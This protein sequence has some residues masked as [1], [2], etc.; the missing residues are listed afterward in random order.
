MSGEWIDHP[1]SHTFTIPYISYVCYL[2]KQDILWLDIP[3]DDI[4]VVHELYR[5]ADLT[6]DAPDPFLPE[7]AL[8][9]EVIVDIPSAA[10]FQHEV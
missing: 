10:E 5:V 2:M 8:F 9:L 1:K 4:A 7:T 3:V 6:S